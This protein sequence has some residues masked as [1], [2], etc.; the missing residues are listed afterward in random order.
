MIAISFLP[1]AWPTFLVEVAIST[2]NTQWGCTSENSRGKM[3]HTIINKTKS[4]THT[5]LSALMAQPIGL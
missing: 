2:L 5:H 3:L 1:I 4:T